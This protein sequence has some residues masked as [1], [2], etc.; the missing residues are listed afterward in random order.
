M[1]LVRREANSAMP[2]S[3]TISQIPNHICPTLFGYV[4]CCSVNAANDVVSDIKYRKVGAN[5][6]RSPAAQ[7]S[8]RIAL[9]ATLIPSI[10]MANDAIVI[11]VAASLARVVGK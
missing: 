7:P 3:E 11:G 10:T 6:N 9:D 4:R 5:N 1:E 8:G 2:S